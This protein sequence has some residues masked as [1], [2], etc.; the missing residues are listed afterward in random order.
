MSPSDDRE[1]IPERLATI[2]KDVHDVTIETLAGLVSIPSLSLPGSSSTTLLQSAHHVQE[3]FAPLLDWRVCEIVQADGGA[4]AVLARKDP[5]PGFPTVLLYAHHDVQ[6][7]GDENA[8][9]SPPFEPTFRD[10]RLYG[11]GSADDGA[12]IVTHLMAV[13]AVTTLLGANPDLGIVVFIEGEEESGSPTFAQLLSDYASELSADVII[14]A[15]SDNPAPDR[16]A[17]TTSL[18]GVLGAT[19]RIRTLQAPRHSGLFGGPTPDA[20]GTLIRVLSSLWDGDGSVAI[21]GVSGDDQVDAELDEQVLREEAGVLPGIGLWGS[22]SL[23]TR[24]WR[25]PSVTVTGIDAPKVSQASNTLSAEARARLSVRIPPGTPGRDALAALEGHL[26][27]V[28]P[29]GVDWDLS[30]TEMGEGFDQSTDHPLVTLLVE[31][32]EWGYGTPVEYQGVGGTIPFVAHL[33]ERFPGALVAVT[34]VE[35]R[36][37]AAHGVDESVDVSMVSRAIASEAAFLWRLN[38]RGTQ[39]GSAGAR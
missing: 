27:S 17:L 19:L 12:G 2:V 37:S 36:Q 26:R 18:R 15:D 1:A 34:G 9:T 13:T 10:G 20:M 31:C 21:A 8:W 33:A 38:D 39:D 14:V 6:P 29:A 35:D 4:P 3:L 16:P 32:L 23:A 24:L 30:D 11:R 28:I 5:S 22:G 25:A 7:A